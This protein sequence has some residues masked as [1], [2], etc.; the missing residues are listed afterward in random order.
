[1]VRYRIDG[2]LHDKI[3]IPLTMHQAIVSRIKVMCELDIAE[4]RK[5][6][7]GRVTVKTSTRMVDMRISTLP[8][9]N[10]GGEPRTRIGLHKVWFLN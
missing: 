2:L 3:H 6:Q 8:T 10:G 5:P 7:D 1:M 9:V 4:R